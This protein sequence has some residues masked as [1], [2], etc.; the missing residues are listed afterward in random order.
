MTALRIKPTI[1]AIDTRRAVQE[2]QQNRHRR[3]EPVALPTYKP[4]PHTRLWRIWRA[5]G[6]SLIGTALFVIAMATF[7][8]WA[9]AI[10]EAT[11]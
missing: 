1:E 10:A 7:A 5:I 9:M 11:R 3:F 2:R 8:G 4:R 6:P